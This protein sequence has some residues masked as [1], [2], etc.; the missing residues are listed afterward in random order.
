MKNWFLLGLIVVIILARYFPNAGR[1]GG[2]V[3]PEYS[4]KYGVTA[5]IFLLSGLSLKTTEILRSAKNYRAHLITQLTSFVAIPL[6]VKCLT[7]LVGLSP[8]EQKP[9]RRHEYHLRHVH[10]RVL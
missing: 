10:H 7:L 9:T 2:P 4:V 3:R 5:C 6:F 8:P 1:T